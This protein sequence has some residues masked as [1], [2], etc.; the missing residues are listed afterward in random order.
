MKMNVFTS[1]PLY[2]FIFSSEAVSI[3]Q[4]FVSNTEFMKDLKILKNAIILAN[5]ICSKIFK[6]QSEIDSKGI[7][8]VAILMV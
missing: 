8:L 4:D 5:L 3:F 6:L 2:F 1:Y 7:S